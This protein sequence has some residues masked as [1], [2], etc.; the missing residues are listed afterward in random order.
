V[1]W[2]SNARVRTSGPAAGL[3]AVVAAEI[4]ILGSLEGLLGR[5]PITCEIVRSSVNIDAGARTKRAA[6]IHGLLLA[7]ALV[8]FPALIN[9]I[10]L[11]CLAAILSATGLRLASP[12]V[13]SGMWRAGRYEFI[14]YV[15]TLVAIIF[16]D[17]LQ[18]ILIGLVV[19]LGF[20]LWSNQ[21]RGSIPSQSC[22]PASTRGRQ[23]SC[24][25]TWDWAM[26]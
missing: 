1:G 12:A 9:R 24:S 23:P 20:I 3:T 15:V 17:P 5:L 6:I 25:S 8:L 13:V 4:A 22:S 14:P 18:G 11:A 26:F 2:I 19:S 21:Q 16:T 7:A 10:P